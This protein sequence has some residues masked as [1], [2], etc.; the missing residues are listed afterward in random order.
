[1]DFN[2]KNNAIEKFYDDY[3]TFNETTKKT[4]S[5][6]VNKLLNDNYIYGGIEED[7]TH[8]DYYEISNLQ[9]SISSYLRMIDYELILK[10]D[11]KI[12]Y[13]E[14]LENR[15]RLR[16]KKFETVVL[17]ILRLLYYKESMSADGNSNIKVSYSEIIDEINL[18]KIF[19]DKEINK[20]QLNETLKLFKRYKIVDFISSNLENDSLITIYPT[21]IFV[22]DVF[23]IEE[24]NKNIESFKKI[25][26]EENEGEVNE[27]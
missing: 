26:K 11:Y 7:N 5:R 12:Y 8:D 24:L 1:M 21:I 19:K 20:T 2:D 13:I 15:N 23:N 17:L 25:Y 6:L 27:D 14:T 22:V 9:D 4:F 16:L 18:T 3:K 10:S